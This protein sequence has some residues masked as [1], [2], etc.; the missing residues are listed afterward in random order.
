[1]ILFRNAA[2]LPASSTVSG[3][4][5]HNFGGEFLKDRAPCLFSLVS[6]V[7]RSRRRR[8]LADR[9]LRAGCVGVWA[10]FN[11]CLYYYYDDD[12][13]YYYDY[14]YYYYYYCVL[15][16]FVVNYCL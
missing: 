11:H 16:H 9:K 6:S 5:F 2:M 13:Y 1:M 12:D 7:E 10:V 4:E 8:E 14:Y 15:S 3:S